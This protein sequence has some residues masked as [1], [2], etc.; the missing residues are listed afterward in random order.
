MTAAQ[1]PPGTEPSAQ[2]H[3]SSLTAFHTPWLTVREAHVPEPGG[4]GRDWYYVDHP[5]CALVLPVTADGTLLL[6]RSWRIAVRR[7]CLEAPAGRCEPGETPRETAVRELAEETG[8]RAEVLHPLG[9]VWPS[10]GS[11]NEEVHLFLA[12]SVAPGQPRLDHGEVI[13]PGPLP[14]EEALELATGGELQDA[15]TALALLR[16]HRRGLLPAP[17]HG[18]ASVPLAQGEPR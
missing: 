4:P 14:V 18:A 11:S 3:G 5:G 7:W 16:A 13:L 2:R 6:I 17:A 1:Y 12:P 9:S 15:P 8:A 10:S